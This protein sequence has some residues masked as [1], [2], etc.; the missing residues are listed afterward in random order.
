VIQTCDECQSQFNIFEEGYGSKFNFVL[1]GKC[2]ATE[3]K[4]RKIGGV[5]T[6]GVAK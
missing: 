2:W 5:F 4:R 3:L 6:E 1:C